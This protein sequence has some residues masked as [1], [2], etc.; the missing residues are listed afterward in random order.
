MAE[1]KRGKM[2]KSANENITAFLAGLAIALAIFVAGALIL[3]FVGCTTT[4]VLT[5]C[6]VLGKH[7][8]ENGD[9]TTRVRILETNEITLRYGDLGN[10]G[11][12]TQVWVPLK[13]LPNKK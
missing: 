5:D 9:V 11:N 3:I 12:T 6:V 4:L 13:D 7:K 1:R 2:K 10:A 8:Y